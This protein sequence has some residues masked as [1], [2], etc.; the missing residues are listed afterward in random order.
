MYG[1]ASA[2]YWAGTVAAMVTAQAVIGSATLD[3]AVV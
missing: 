2:T 1:E 3:P